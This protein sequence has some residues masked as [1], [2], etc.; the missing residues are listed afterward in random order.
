VDV[1]VTTS[2]SYTG[3]W[4]FSIRAVDGFGAPTGTILATQTLNA[5]EVH[6]NDFDFVN[7]TE[8]H[9]TTPAT[10]SPGVPFAIC[11]SPE[12]PVSGAGQGKGYWRGTKDTGSP[13][14]Y[15]GGT[16]FHSLDGVHFG[17]DTPQYDLLFRTY[18]DGSITP[19]PAAALP[20]MLLLLSRR[21]CRM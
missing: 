8:M 6:P 11:V 3:D 5:A 21:R 15:G 9:F 4:T 13:A 12:P 10:V 1:W 18:V 20:A 17:V 16:A 19:E 2:D 14:D 7:P